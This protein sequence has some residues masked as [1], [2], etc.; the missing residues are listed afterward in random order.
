MH[1]AVT[2]DKLIVQLWQKLANK[3]RLG[4][5]IEQ[6]EGLYFARIFKASEEDIIKFNKDVQEETSHGNSM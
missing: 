2:G 4:L 5:T 3:Y 1:Q 6:R